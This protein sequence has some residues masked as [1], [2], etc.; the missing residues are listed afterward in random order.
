MLGNVLYIYEYKL[1]L[2]LLLFLLF[3]ILTP[4][5]PFFPPYSLELL[6]PK[7]PRTE[8]DKKNF[9]TKARQNVVDEAYNRT[10]IELEKQVLNEEYTKQKV[11][12]GKLCSFLPWTYICNYA[13]NDIM[14]YLVVN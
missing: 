13:E 10:L 4:L 8:Q 11:M 7:E 9:S 5:S 1:L 3:F 2:L 12:E 14:F 6:L